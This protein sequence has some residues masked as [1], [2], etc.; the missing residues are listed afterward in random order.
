MIKAHYKLLLIKIWTL[1]KSKRLLKSLKKEHLEEHFLEIFI[2]G[3]MI[4]GTET[5][6]KNFTG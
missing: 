1:V 5:H 2:L 4:D 3:L 6:K